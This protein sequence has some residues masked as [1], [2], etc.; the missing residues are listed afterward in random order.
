MHF[1]RARLARKLL[2]NKLVARLHADRGAAFEWAIGLTVQM[3]G[4]GSLADDE[5][6]IPSPYWQNSD[7][8][9]LQYVICRK[10]RS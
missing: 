9:T 3:H 4:S 6:G 1:T 10:Q 8:L 7:E 2:V 5:Q